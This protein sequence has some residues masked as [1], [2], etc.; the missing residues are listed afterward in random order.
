MTPFQKTATAALIATACL[1]GMDASA[2][3][4]GQSAISQMYWNLVDLDP[5]DGITPA[6]TFTN[7]VLQHETMIRT[8]NGVDRQEQ[9]TILGN[10]PFTS[11]LDFQGVTGTSSYGNAT[12]GSMGNLTQSGY[13]WVEQKLSGDFTLTPN[14]IMEYGGILSGQTSIGNVPFS[15]GTNCVAF[16][17]TTIDS[18]TWVNGQ[19][20]QGYTHEYISAGNA[21]QTTGFSRPFDFAA[22][23][24]ST[25]LATG[26]FQYKT[27]ASVNVYAQPVPEPETWAMMICGLAVSAMV[28]R[29]RKQRV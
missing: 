5:N 7:F 21:N 20:S 26:H 29:R 14:T 16:A 24:W 3:A 15:C 19:V 1:T 10:S 8:A 28:V 12:L 25:N 4:T 6:V 17:L 22:V 9:H 18:S 27:F 23:N 2:Q 11:R 13:A